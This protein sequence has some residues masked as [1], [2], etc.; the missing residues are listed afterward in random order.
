MTAGPV[1]HSCKQSFCGVVIAYFQHGIQQISLLCLNESEPA[2]CIFGGLP[3]LALLTI[4]S[5]FCVGMSR[6]QQRH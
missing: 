4:E 5:L 1:F 3:L 6:F 2:K